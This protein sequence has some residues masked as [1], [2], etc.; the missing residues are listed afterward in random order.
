MRS[1][2]HGGVLFAGEKGPKVRLKINWSVKTAWLTKELL[3]SVYEL[4]VESNDDGNSNENN[5]N[6]NKFIKQHNN[7]LHEHRN[8]GRS[9]D[10][11]FFES[12]YEL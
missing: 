2:R 12:F 9:Q 6:S 4:L 5:K 8:R 10:D 7:T 11:D 3:A 1:L